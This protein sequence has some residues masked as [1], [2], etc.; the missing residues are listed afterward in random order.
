MTQ[1]IRLFFS[2]ISVVDM[3]EEESKQFKS[4]QEYLE[5]KWN[6]QK[7]A[8]KQ[9][10]NVSSFDREWKDKGSAFVVENVKNRDSFLDLL[11]FIFRSDTLNVED[12]FVGKYERGEKY[13][14]YLFNYNRIMRNLELNLLFQLLADLHDITIFSMAQPEITRKEGA[15]LIERFQHLLMCSVAAYTS[16]SYSQ[17]ISDNTK[18][19]IRRIRGIT[20]SHKG[21]KHGRY[22]TTCRGKK[23][24][25]SPRNA[26]KLYKFVKL[27]LK[28][29]F[30]FTE[31]KRAVADDFGLSV[32]SAFISKIKQNGDDEE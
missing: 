28:E 9:F 30:T 32:S 31:I 22:F 16:E 3:D 19:A 6:Q 7:E 25:L 11:R 10:F 26:E 29:R 15:S 23:K 24:Q 1:T 20:L 14:L 27:K 21:N 8:V 5:Y 12:L 13:E 17:D 2:R 18:K 4:E